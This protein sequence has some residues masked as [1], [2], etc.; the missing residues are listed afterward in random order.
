MSIKFSPFKKYVIRAINPHNGAYVYSRTNDPE[1]RKDMLRYNVA[2]INGNGTAVFERFNMFKGCDP[3]EVK[4]EVY[5]KI[6]G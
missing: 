4:F 2:S 6:E 3:S 1:G 5:E